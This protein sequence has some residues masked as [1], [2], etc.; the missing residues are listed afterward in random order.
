MSGA[1]FIR[2]IGAG[3]CVV[4]AGC[5]TTPVDSRARI[6]DVPLASTHADIA[7]S[8]TTGSRQR[9]VCVGTENCQELADSDQVVRFALQVERVAEVLQSGAESLYPDLAARLPGLAH[10]RFDVYVAD[11]NEPGSA[12]SANGRIALNSALGVWRPYDEWLAFVIAREMGHVIARHHEENSA[13]SLATSVI[14]NI[15]IPGSGLLKSAM[16]AGGS[17][18]ASVSKRS[19]QAREADAI[20]FKLLEVSGFR[21]RDVSLSLRT[22]A[23]LPDDSGWSNSFRKSSEDFLAEVHNSEPAVVSQAPHF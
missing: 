20:A 15:L 3:A 22:A 10:G 12:S 7:F 8:M 9:P 21:L 17:R 2:L 23:A 13:A 4:I 14:M 18:I 6:I 16:S 1:S 19:V 11:D 5:A